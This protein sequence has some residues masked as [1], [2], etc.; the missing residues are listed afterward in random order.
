MQQRARCFAIAALLGAWPAATFA[1]SNFSGFTSG[2]IIVSRSVYVGDSSTV[3]KGQ[4]L[5][6]LCPSGA[7]CAKNGAVATN[8]G[9]YPGVWN[10]DAIDGSFGITSPI[11]LD[12]F[13]PSGA[14]VN[15]LP[16]PPGMIVT[17]FSSKSELALNKSTDGGS[18]SFMGYVAP[19]NAIDVSNSNTPG[20]Y[21]PT[22]PAGGSY[23][24]GVAQIFPNGA[25]QVTPTNAYSGNNGRAAILGNGLFYMV[26]NSNNG[27]G[28]P[29][30]VVAAAGAQV[31][32]PG[33]PG[34]TA[35]QEIGNF[36][37]TTVID[38]AT[39]KNYTT[40]DKPGKDNNFRGLTIFGN[41][42]YVTKGS[43]GN[44]IDTVYQVGNAGSLPTLANA[45][46]APLTILPG[47]NTASAKEATTGPN[48]FG[49]WF[50]NATTLY[51]AD[52]G[53]GVVADAA[54]S[55]FAGL[56]KWSLANGTWTLDYV[57]TSGLNLGVQYSVANYPS[58]LSPATD[59]LRNI[60]GVLN[61][62][63][64]VTIYAVT[65]TVSTSGDQGADPNMVVKITDTLANTTAPSNESF[66]VFLAPQAGVVY[67]GVSPTPVAPI[68]S[69]VTASSP[70]IYSAAS[71]GVVGVAPGSLAY[72]FAPGLS[73]TDPG[74]IL[75]VLPD[76]F[77]GTT[78]SFKDA[79]GN[80]NLAPLFYVS[81]SELSFEV[82]PSAA[83]GTATVTV[84]NSGGS[85]T[86]SNVVIATTAPGLFSL[87]NSGLAAAYAT[88][89]SGSTATTELAYQLTATN[90]EF[91]PLPISLGASTDT[92]YLTL[93]GTGFDAA[94]KTNTTVTVNGTSVSVLYAGTQSQY[95][96]LDQVNIQLPNS[97]AGS[98]N[99]DV[100]ATF[101][102][103]QANP[104][105]ITI[106]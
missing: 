41:T 78:V 1:Q 47:F 2:N 31:A 52:E 8:D 54:T 56:Q 81:P 24:R 51:V 74:P 43:G 76:E 104:V 27:G 34:T 9:T 22:N 102:G 61:G 40:A 35:P 63:G 70:V 90:G 33:Q 36:N 3:T 67:R 13:T 62:D 50:A 38:P 32:T 103:V 91:L 89:V 95:T 80:T 49:I 84:T 87:G 17:S 23:Y 100:I 72:A 19:V 21:D 45:A 44:G 82:P 18:I 57:L 96:G 20:V 106:K 6:P 64:T 66:S 93:Y 65:S 11:F 75:G 98:G 37:I 12:Q 105:Q 73:P 29:A 60:N 83:P 59:G 85:E 10:N 92:T 28:T 55:K 53:D 16:I 69:A 99:V 15:T 39:G 7:S 26:G 79:A 14:L 58:S 30:N 25:I 5:P 48:P 86:A 68:G 77:G 94:S 101:N 88:R 42:L 71:P 4:F 46:N 97:L